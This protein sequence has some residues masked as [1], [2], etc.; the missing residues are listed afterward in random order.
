MVD[1]GF[2][3]RDGFSF[4]RIDGGAVQ[5]TYAPR[6]EVIAQTVVPENEWGSVVAVVSEAGD[7]AAAYASARAFH[8]GRCV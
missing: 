5:I 3:V 6:G 2:H 7:T 8:M 4:K 1:Q